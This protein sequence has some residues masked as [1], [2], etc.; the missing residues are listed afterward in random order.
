MHIAYF[1]SN[2]KTGLKRNRFKGESVV[3]EAVENQDGEVGKI[4]QVGEAKEKGRKRNGEKI[5]R[6][7]AKHAGN[8]IMCAKLGRDKTSPT[9]KTQ[10]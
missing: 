5:I 9:M 3:Q 7:T 10:Q 6:D 4:K 1:L 8:K 2:T